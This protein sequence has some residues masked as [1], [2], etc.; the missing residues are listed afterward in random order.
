[1]SKRDYYEVL[2]VSRNAS[3]Q[4]LK[5]AYRKLAVK[6]HPD[7]NQGDT[8][9]EEQFKEAAEAYS[10]LSN[11]DQ[12]ARYDR[13]G[14]EGVGAGANANWGASGFGNIEDILGDIFGFG[15]VFGGGRSSS[16]A[17]RANAP[18]R[19]SDLRYDLE[20]TLEDAIEG[21]SAP[22]RIPRLEMCDVCGGNGAA[23][24]TK[25]DTCATCNGTGQVRYQQG[26]FA[27][28]RTCATCRGTGQVTRTPCEKCEGYGR[29]E[30]EKT[31][32]VKIPAGVETGSRLRVSGEGEGGTNNGPA[33]DLYVVI[34]VKE[35]ERFERQGANLYTVTPLTFSQAALGAELDV[36]T[37]GKDENEKLK[38]PAGT[39][40]GSVFRVKGKGMPILGGRGRGDLFVAAQVVTPKKLTREQ[41]TLFEQLAEVENEEAGDEGL[42]GKVRSIFG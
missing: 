26:F 6:H 3:E 20:I 10:V 24:G 17:R 39:Q 4:E 35:H 42:L 25:P 13:F 5:S 41:R 1:M 40:S 38:I 33:G 28:A 37:I 32:D 14:H 7:K 8:K 21:L 15:D 22:L 36:E 18:Q 23:K 11:A 19:G 29:I 30:N 34:S 27:V 2:G 16:S 31:I 9:A 12:R